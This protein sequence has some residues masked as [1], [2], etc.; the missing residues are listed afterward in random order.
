MYDS[1]LE[2][3][4]LFVYRLPVGSMRNTLTDRIIFMTSKL[5]G[6]QKLMVLSNQRAEIREDSDQV[7]SLCTDWLKSAI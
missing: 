6:D 3:S 2:H 5:A 4:P 1:G 7:S